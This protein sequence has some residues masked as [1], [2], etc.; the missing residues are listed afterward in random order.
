MLSIAILNMHHN[1]LGSLTRAL[2]NIGTKVKCVETV[3]ELQK[4]DGIILPGVGSFNSTITS[5]EE[6][7]EKER[8]FETITNSKFVLGI[9]L[10]MHLL[11][12]SST[13]GGYSLG[14][15]II[16]GRVDRLPFFEGSKVPNMGWRCTALTENT[17]IKLSL[18]NRFF[19]HVHSFY[20]QASESANVYGTSFHNNMEYP[21]IIGKGHIIGM[22]F[23]PEISS[24][25]GEIL[26]KK[27]I[28][29]FMD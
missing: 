11:A 21:T 20:Y 5:L 10:G 18:E 29:Y 25:D 19:Y 24:K 3:K 1:N 8:L 13:E 2:E 6:S 12:T 22:Q 17:P 16:P 7:G 23:H 27:I 14:L 15:N 9:C 26:L 4:E 28:D